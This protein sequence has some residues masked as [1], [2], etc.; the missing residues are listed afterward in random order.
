[1]AT[2]TVQIAAPCEAVY[3]VIADA[4][5]WERWLT[6]HGGWPDGPPDAL[7]QGARFRQTAVLLTVPDVVT[8]TVETDAPQARLALRGKGSW[9]VAA[10]LSFACTGDAQTT[11]VVAAVEFLVPAIGPLR[12]LRDQGAALVVED[13]A[14]SLRRLDAVLRGE[15]PDAIP[16]P[17]IGELPPA[18]A[19]I[20]RL[21]G[22]IRPQADAHDTGADVD[23][24]IDELNRRTA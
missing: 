2:S 20:V 12:G 23:R 18:V 7:H 14:H 15:D 8:W 1:M 11:S 9:G 5:G 17:V 3:E 22:R 24:A 21:V 19:M 4:A 13:V 10:R 6:T 16:A